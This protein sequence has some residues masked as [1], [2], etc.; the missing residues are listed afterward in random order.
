VQ[1][2]LDPACVTVLLIQTDYI[3]FV[4]AISELEGALR[5]HNCN[6]TATVLRKAQ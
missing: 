3:R 5:E 6:D 4:A 2:D 1:L